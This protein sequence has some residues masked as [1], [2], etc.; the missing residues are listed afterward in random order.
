VNGVPILTANVRDGRSARLSED[1][2]VYI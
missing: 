1:F 2:R